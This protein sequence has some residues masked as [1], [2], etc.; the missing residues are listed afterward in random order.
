MDL[1]SD[2]KAVHITAQE[3]FFDVDG[4]AQKIISQVKKDRGTYVKLILNKD[5]KIE[6]RTGA[7]WIIGDAVQGT[8]QDMRAL[9][10]KIQSTSKLKV[11]M[12][13]ERQLSNDEYFARQQR[14]LNKM[15]F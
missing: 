9:A 7:G 10:A 6:A 11:R 12:A 1:T 8:E 15:G 3:S 5:G 14:K 2:T 13:I 4:T